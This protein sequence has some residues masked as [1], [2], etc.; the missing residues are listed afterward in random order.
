VRV[1]KR[2]KITAAQQFCKREPANNVLAFWEISDHNGFQVF[3]SG[4]L[5]ARMDLL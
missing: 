1:A 2:A 4:G 3:G 5:P